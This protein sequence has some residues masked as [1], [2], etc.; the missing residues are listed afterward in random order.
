MMGNSTRRVLLIANACLALGGL[1]NAFPKPCLAEGAVVFRSPAL[2]PGA[3]KVDFRRWIS[4]EWYVMPPFAG[5]SVNAGYLPQSQAFG[6][7]IRTYAIPMMARIAKRRHL[8]AA[9][10]AFAAYQL[11]MGQVRVGETLADVASLYKGCPWL[12]RKMLHHAKGPLS[13]G[14]DSTAVAIQLASPGEP[15]G[16]LLVALTGKHP[17]SEVY[18]Q[19][20]G[21]QHTAALA[22]RIMAIGVSVSGPEFRVSGVPHTTRTFWLLA[23]NPVDG[24]AVVGLTLSGWAIRHYVRPNAKKSAQRTAVIAALSMSEMPPHFWA[25][26]AR[27]RALAERQRRFA[28]MMFLITAVRP[29]ETVRDLAHSMSGFPRLQHGDLAYSPVETGPLLFATM[30][31]NNGKLYSLSLKIEAQQWVGFIWISLVHHLRASQLT[32][33]LNGQG[34]SACFGDTVIDLGPHWTPYAKGYVSARVK[35]ALKLQRATKSKTAN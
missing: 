26:L 2:S 29:G 32:K 14:G 5:L 33:C 20:K 10:R 16:Q 1:A 15:H 24:R 7:G 34:A 28:E 18:K 35:A 4:R 30:E 27:T 11:F 21:G 6:A 8:P 31:A 17:L 22:E 3:T 19:L 13:V 25:T 9:W 12:H 23:P